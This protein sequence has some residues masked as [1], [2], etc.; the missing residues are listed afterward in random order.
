M[1]SITVPD[2]LPSLKVIL[3]LP[4]ETLVL[5]VMTILD[6]NDTSD[7]PSVGLK[8]IACGGTSNDVAVTIPRFTFLSSSNTVTPETLIAIFY[9]LGVS[10]IYQ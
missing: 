2:A 5:Y 4:L 10:F 8:V 1:V 6:V 3:P 9:L 7:E